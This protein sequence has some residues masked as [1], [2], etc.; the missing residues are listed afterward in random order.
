[1]MRHGFSIACL[2]V[3]HV[4]GSQVLAGH[5]GLVDREPSAGRSVKTE[6]GYMIPYQQV[7]PGTEAFFEMVPVPG[8][9]FVL[10]SPKDEKGRNDDEGPQVSIQVEPFW[11]SKTEVT[12]KE[13][14]EF[15]K[16]YV[17]LKEIQGLRYLLTDVDIRLDGKSPRQVERIK[18]EAS[19]RKAR[20]ASLRARLS[21]R[22]LQ[23]LQAHL[24]H[25]PDGLDAVTA[26]TELYEPDITYEFGSRPDQPA[27]TMTQYAAK[28][29]SKWL[30]KLTDRFYR[31]PSEAEWEYACRAGS[32]TAY[33]FGDDASLL[34]KYAWY[35]KNAKELPTVG[36]K[37]PNAWGLHDMHGSVSEWVLDAYDPDGYGAR[38]KTVSATAAL[39]W[40]Q[41]AYPRVVRGGSWSDD[42]A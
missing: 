33:H 15:M 21:S 6:K 7:I 35:R 40:P 37:K 38:E 29:Y 41:K 2:F 1:M 19:R 30:S 26:P 20:Q 24:D 31:L 18:K 22:N 39:N 36:T 13:Y 27:V 32:Q 23:A 17:A 25:P 11:I 8:G 16:L 14:Q 28:Q 34:G 5:P 42:P 4:A 12:W 10:G 3:M 9:T